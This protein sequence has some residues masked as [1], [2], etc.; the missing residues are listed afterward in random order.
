MN[1]FTKTFASI[2][3]SIVSSVVEAKVNKLEKQLHDSIVPMSNIMDSIIGIGSTVTKKCIKGYANIV[4]NNKKDIID[5][6]SENANT[7][8]RIAELV[9]QLDTERNRLLLSNIGKSTIQTFKDINDEMQKEFDTDFPLTIKPSCDAV[10][11]IWDIKSRKRKVSDV[12]NAKPTIS[13]SKMIGEGKKVMIRETRESMYHDVFEMR[14]WIDNEEIDTDGSD[15]D[16]ANH[17]VIDTV[18]AGLIKDIYFYDITLDTAEQI[19]SRF[20]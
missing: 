4:T 11:D 9:Q 17:E 13:I 19:D 3:S 1:F 8:K 16:W 12:V 5:L 15:F 7:L 14:M 2:K 20:L 6:V 18:E 10:N